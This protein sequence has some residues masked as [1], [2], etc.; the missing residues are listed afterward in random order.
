M[1]NVLLALVFGSALAPAALGCR[2]GADDRDRP[3]PSVPVSVATAVKKD[4]P[5]RLSAIGAVE[6]IS[7]V[8]ITPQVTGLVL[9]VHFKEGD[10][11]ERDDVLF[12]IDT[13]PY[14]ATLRAAYAQLGKNQ[15]LAA[16]ARQ[17]AER[18][19]NLQREG[20][21]SAQQ[22]DQARANAESLDASLEADRAA[23]R[24]ASL[25][26]QFT[27]V[28]SPIDGRTGSLLVHAGNLVRANE[29]RPLVVIRTL[30]PALVRFA[31]PQEHL[32]RIRERFRDSN[33]LVTA[34]PRGHGGTVARGRLDF[35]ENTVDPATGTIGLKAVFDNA[36]QALWPGEFVNA[37]LELSVERNV[38]VIPEAAVQQ[39]QDSSFTYVLGPQNRVQLR[40]IEVDRIVQGE[41]VIRSGL[42]PGDRVVVD[43]QVR[44]RDGAQA[45]VKPAP[46][47]A[48]KPRS[49]ESEGPP[50]MPGTGHGP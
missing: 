31:L 19:F 6:P 27:T 7:T 46:P 20:V 34:E 5:L 45:S 10:F 38:T 29:D 18:Y 42:V 48:I 9:Q 8:E 33:L 17:E 21:A 3:A 2:G 41:A 43:G 16:Q 49:P 12:T 25:N 30:A 13:R 1:R 37:S 24:S 40:R 23:I 4:V 11:V 39:G 22:Y 50:V 44:L 35:L 14:T 28:K 15:A 26:V 36:D 47:S 32:P